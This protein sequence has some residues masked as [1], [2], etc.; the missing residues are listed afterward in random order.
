MPDVVHRDLKEVGVHGLLT[1]AAV[2]RMSHIV[3]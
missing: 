1:P 3:T 2:C